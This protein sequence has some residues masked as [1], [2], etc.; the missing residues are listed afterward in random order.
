MSS[1]KFRMAEKAI[2]LVK[3]YKYLGV[4][5]LNSSILD[6]VHQLLQNQQ[7]EHYF[8]YISLKTLYKC[9]VQDFY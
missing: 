2:E 6:S 9:K 8:N 4:I 5:L 3:N 1:F 7:E